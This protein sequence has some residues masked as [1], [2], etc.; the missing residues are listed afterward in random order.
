MTFSCIRREVL[1]TKDGPLRV[2]ASFPHKAYIPLTVPHPSEGDDPEW[3]DSDMNE[4]HE[5]V[6]LEKYIPVTKS[7]YNSILAD[8]DSVLPIILNPDEKAIVRYQGTS[9]VIGRSGTGKTTAL[10][11][12]MRANAQVAQASDSADS[13]RQLFV[14]RSPVLTRRVASYYN[15]LIESGEIANKTPEELQIMRQLNQEYQPRDLLEFDNEADLRDDLPDRYSELTGGH[16]PLFISFDKLAQ[17]LEADALG[18]NDALTLA[19]VRLKRLVDFN[20]F[21]HQY[22]P[23]FDYNLTRRLDPALVFSEIMGVIKGYGHDLSEDE[24]T[25]N[26]TSKKSPLLAD[27]RRQ[28]YAIFKAY[29]KRCKI[30]GET[31]SADRA[32]SIL[33]VRKDVV[34]IGNRV[35]YL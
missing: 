25:N 28:V 15:A 8:M 30:R 6:V 14:T 31:D 29:K 26:L 27:V 2:P 11:Y 3:E 17:L 18:T 20:L 21:K 7:L 32:R 9:V 1:N 12:K 13:L 33:S 35:D 16:F 4:L 24:Y 10:V 5:A 22:W 19:R 23:K 34:D